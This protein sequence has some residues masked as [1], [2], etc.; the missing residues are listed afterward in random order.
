MEA[1]RETL[2]SQEEQMQR[3]ME[4]M[5][6]QIAELE[7]VA[8][9][10]PAAVQQPAMAPAAL[11]PSAP[12]ALQEA[13]RKALQ[14]QLP[15]VSPHQYWEPLPAQVPA[16]QQQ[17]QL[18]T[19]QT[20]WGPMLV[21]GPQHGAALEAPLQAPGQ[22]LQQELAL[23]SPHQYWEPWPGQAAPLAGGLLQGLPPMAPQSLPQGLPPMSPQ[24][25]PQGAQQGFGWPGAYPA[26]ELAA[27][28]PRAAPAPL[29][30]Q[31]EGVFAQY[32][33][34]LQRLFR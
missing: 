33:S 11:P 29:E 2:L 32:Q 15:Q 6:R 1:M 10:Q 16:P 24:G 13:A 4:Q 8:A 18:W 34:L 17:P 23:A 21:Q 31:Q 14:P 25:L 19:V 3:Q 12:L 30:P 27:L 20:P 7:R 22:A 5:Q 9:R 28:Q 26:Q